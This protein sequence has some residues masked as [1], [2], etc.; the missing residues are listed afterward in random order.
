MARVTVDK[1]ALNA[2]IEYANGKRDQSDSQ[3]L[4]SKKEHE[5]SEQEFDTLVGRLEIS[6]S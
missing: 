1:D 4:A 3:F 2:L 6:D 5:E